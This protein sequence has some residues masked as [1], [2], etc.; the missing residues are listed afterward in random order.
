MADTMGGKT[1]APTFLGASGA[2]TSSATT[3]SNHYSRIV[4]RKVDANILYFD[5]SAD[6][7][8]IA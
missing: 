7:I 2:T 3:T 5:P 8:E 4:G 6:F 1:G